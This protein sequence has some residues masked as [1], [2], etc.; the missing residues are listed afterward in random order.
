MKYNI[1][2]HRNDNSIERILKADKV[3]AFA[4]GCGILSVI[5]DG[6]N[7][8]YPLDTIYEYRIEDVED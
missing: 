3:E 7:R 8:C 1:E 6:V 5:Q 2:I 4:V